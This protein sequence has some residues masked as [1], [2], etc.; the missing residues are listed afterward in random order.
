MQNN[1]KLTRRR[2]VTVGSAVLGAATLPGI[3]HAAY[4]KKQIAKLAEIKPGEPIA[5]SYPDNEPAYLLDMGRP[6]AGGAGPRRSLVAYSALCQH[7][8][9]PVNY[10]AKSGYFVCPCHASMFDPAKD[11]DVVDGASIY[12]LPRI[13]LRVSG[14]TVYAVGVHSGIVYG[15]ACNQ[16]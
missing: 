6:V 16:S 2:F 12:G 11:G 1:G 15:R 7:M 10:N 9:C 3:A 14:D 5:F 13:S 8:G 4:T